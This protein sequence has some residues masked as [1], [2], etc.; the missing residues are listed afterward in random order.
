MH[1]F[2]VTPPLEWNIE[3]SFSATASFTRLI[4][5]AVPPEA[6]LEN[7]MTGMNEPHHKT[8]RFPTVS[9]VHVQPHPYYACSWC[10][11]RVDIIPLQT[12]K[13]E[14]IS[15][16]QEEYEALTNRK[17]PKKVKVPESSEEFLSEET[18]PKKRKPARRIIVHEVSSAEESDG[19]DVE[20]V[21]PKVKPPTEKEIQYQSVLNKMFTYQWWALPLCW[22][23]FPANLF[24]LPFCNFFAWLA[25][26]CFCLSALVLV[27]LV[28]GIFYV[29]V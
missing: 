5:E 22:H 27:T 10:S 24:F 12:Q 28:C 15:K 8:D 3:L 14:R 20:V 21:L 13:Q 18:T 17:E 16:V 23:M 4:R 26:W 1:G 25:Q 7:H 9:Q 2:S 19:E 6:E 11:Y 29:H